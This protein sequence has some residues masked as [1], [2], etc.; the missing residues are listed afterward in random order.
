MANANVVKLNRKE[1]QGLRSRRRILDAA[2]GLM[3]EGSYAGTSI[4]A[5]CTRSGL[6]PTSI[7]WHFESKEGLLAAVIEEG[8]NRW[9]DGFLREQRP[10]GSPQQ[11][12]EQAL[13]QV[14]VALEREPEFLR[15]LM[16]LALERKKTDPVSLKA[17]RGVRQMAL[18]RI[19]VML[20]MAFAP[21]GEVRAREVAAQLSV[22]ALAF[23]DGAF[24]AHHIDPKTTD[25]HLL[26]Q[27]LKTALLSLG[28]SLAGSTKGRRNKSNRV[29][30]HD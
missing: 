14:A 29:T 26:F 3:A 15:L 28:E 16:M 18:D 10:E 27:Q 13:D 1:E 19:G 5:I 23:A 20:A 25:L 21:L 8:A 17:I 12:L 9:F 7:Y 4:S 30:S 2:A 22:F 11:R 24:L 6:P